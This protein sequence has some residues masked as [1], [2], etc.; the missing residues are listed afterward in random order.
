MEYGLVSQKESIAEASQF[1][2]VEK[3]VNEGHDAIKLLEAGWND[4]MGMNSHRGELKSRF[5][6]ISNKNGMHEN[7]Q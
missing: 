5:L 7:A 4:E 2:E 6:H 3:N 1:A